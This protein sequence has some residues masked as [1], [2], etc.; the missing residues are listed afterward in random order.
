M[1]NRNEPRDAIAQRLQK[2]RRE[3]ESRKLDGYLVA[4]RRD[5]YWLTGFT[6]ENGFTLV[7]PRQ[8]ALLT[9]GRFTETARREAP[10]ARAIIRTKRGI[11][12]TARLMKPFKL[13][14]LGFDPADLS[15]STFADLRRHLAPTKLTPVSGLID[16]LRLI[17]DAGEVEA[18]RRAVDVA[19]RAF[20]KATARLTP[21]MSERALAARLAFEMQTLGAEEPAFGVNVSAGESACLPHYEPSPARRLDGQPILIDWGARVDWYV[22]DLTRVLPGSSMPP[23]LK[24]VY[25]VVRD[26]HDRAVE[27]VRPGIKAGAV[28]QAARGVIQRAGFGKAFNH[29]LGHGIGLDVHEGPRVGKKADNL[30]QPGMVLTIEPGVYL[31]G[32][33]GIRIESDVLVTPDG[34]EVLSDLP[35]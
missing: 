21:R 24:K 19:Q 5:Q 1:P 34:R 7:T 26:A 35:Y 15:V 30:L 27:A 23:R 17:K 29:A 11:Q 20:R 32:L 28:D 13:E 31:P 25:E 2:V 16:D 18:I 22:S 3:M 4:D 14:R 6:G 8:V 33:G 10:W 9:D 12:D